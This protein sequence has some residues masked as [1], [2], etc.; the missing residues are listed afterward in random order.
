M[1]PKT[2]RRHRQGA[3]SR[4][5][6]LEAA[7]EIAAERGYD[8]MTVASVTERTGLPASSVYWH[9]RNKDALVAE[10]LEY[11]Y[12]R[13]LVSSLTWPQ[14]EAGLEPLERLRRRPRL[15]HERLAAQ[16]EF[17][18][19]G[20]MLGLIDPPQPIAGRD[21]YLEVRAQAQA[22][23]LAWVG[24]QLPA[25]LRSR[26]PDLV[27]HLAQLLTACTDGLFRADQAGREWDFGRLADDVGAALAVYSQSPP[28]RRSRRTPTGHRH[29][30]ATRE[31]PADSRDRLLAATSQIAAERGY[32]GATISAI[33]DRSGLPV[34]SLYW[35]FSDKDELISEVVDRS[36]RQWRQN[37]GR[38]TPS[39]SRNRVRT[40]RR[41]LRRA[42]HALDVDA[43]DFLRIGMLATLDHHDGETSVRSR[44]LSIRRASEDQLAAW[45]T[46]TLTDEQRAADPDVGRELAQLV[47]AFMDGLFLGRRMDE[48]DHDTDTFVEGVIAL[49]EIVLQQRTGATDLRDRLAAP[50]PE[51][52]GAEPEEAS[53]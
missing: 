28:G 38:W 44:F 12:E 39:D 7:L 1:P 5:R 27:L 15:N 18:R 51:R 47:L 41:V 14:E 43:P 25:T 11:S 37:Q 17:W 4:Q 30:S 35:F 22:R 16:P 50:L 20:L 46:S 53:A 42:A 3:E 9:F 8:G 29:Q 26:R 52:E 2:E 21:R 13:W 45:W 40:L 34:S 33:C 10:T 6:I 19:I 31:L 49:L 24:E 32:I 36:F 23:T 48:W